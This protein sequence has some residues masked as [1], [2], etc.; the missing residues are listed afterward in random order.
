MI[1]RSGDEMGALGDV[2]AAPLLRLCQALRQLGVARRRLPQRPADP[3][4]ALVNLTDEPC[5]STLPGR[6]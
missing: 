4:G 6:P 1:G 2:H 5:G 3:G